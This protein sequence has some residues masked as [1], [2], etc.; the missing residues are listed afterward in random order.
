MLLVEQTRERHMPDAALGGAGCLELAGAR[1]DGLQQITEILKR[2]IR[3]DLT[4]AGIEIDEP[5]RRERGAGQIG[6][7]LMMHHRNLDGDDADGIAVGTSAAI[8]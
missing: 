8:A 2:R 1:P 5:Q 4:A 3:P 6:E 7:P